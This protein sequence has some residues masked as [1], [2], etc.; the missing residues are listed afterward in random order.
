[1]PRENQNRYE[2]VAAQVKRVR[3]L[4]SQ[5]GEPLPADVIIDLHRCLAPA[6]EAVDKQGRGEKKQTG[7]RVRA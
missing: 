7:K 6:L 1:M 4:Y 3:E 5:I 2:R